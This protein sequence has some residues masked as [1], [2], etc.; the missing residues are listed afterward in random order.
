MKLALRDPLLDRVTRDQE[1]C[2]GQPVIRGTRILVTLVLD[3]LAEGMKLP[4]V[5]ADYPQLED[6]DVRAA[7]AH[8]AEAIRQIYHSSYAFEPPDDPRVRIIEFESEGE[9]D[10]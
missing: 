10:V 9:W 7:V 3:L 6:A 1:V 8:G 5:L 4:E 2:E